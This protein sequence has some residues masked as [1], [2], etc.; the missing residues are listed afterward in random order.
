MRF[1]TGYAWS[2][3]FLL[4]WYF[5][6]FQQ[7]IGFH[8]RKLLGRLNNAFPQVCKIQVCRLSTSIRFCLA[9]WRTADV[10]EPIPA[11]K[12]IIF[13]RLVSPHRWPWALCH[14][15]NPSNLVAWNPWLD[16]CGPAAPFF[17]QNIARYTSTIL[18]EISTN[19]P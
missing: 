4:V 1:Y 18:P 17:W 12:Q 6:S 13:K 3:L 9:A 16:I 10:D 7:N 2:Y 19:I 15:P 5:V 14:R 11:F 8:H